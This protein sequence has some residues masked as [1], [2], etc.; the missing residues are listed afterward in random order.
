MVVRDRRKPSGDMPTGEE[1]DDDVATARAEGIGVLHG[2]AWRRPGVERTLVQPHRRTHG[3]DTRIARIFNTYGPRMR[4]HDGRVV[5]NFIVQALERK[6]LTVYGHGEQ[7]RSFCYVTDEVQ[8][9]LRLL[10]APDTEDIH[11]PV[12]IGNPEERTVLELAQK[13]LALTESSS[14]IVFE[15]L[16][17]DDPKVR[18]PDITRAQELLGWCPSVPLEEGLRHTVAYFKTCDAGA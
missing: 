6:P 16:P 8:G 1:L 15:P 7:T 17:P 13:I 18:R 14:P 12:N 5:S 3:V 10:M 9:L 2:L 11:L 4:P